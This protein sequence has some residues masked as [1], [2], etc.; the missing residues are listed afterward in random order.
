MIEA[1]VKR[2]AG[3][4][5]HK[6]IVVATILSEQG[7]GE[8]EET[9]KEFKTFPEDL[10][11]LADWLY[12]KKVELTVMETTGVCWKNVYKVLEERTLKVYAVNA[13]HVIS[14]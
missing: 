4:D 7:N 14:C 6:S 1:I 10:K 8:L 12:T 11:K 2:S 13:R 5:V 9:T 3:L